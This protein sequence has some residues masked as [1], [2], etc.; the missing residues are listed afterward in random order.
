[1]FGTE[2]QKPRPPASLDAEQQLGFAYAES[3]LAQA[4]FAFQRLV[5]QDIQVCLVGL[6]DFLMIELCPLFAFLIK[7]VSLV[8]YHTLS[9]TIEWQSL[10]VYGNDRDG[11][12]GTWTKTEK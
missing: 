1:M 3:T 2:S 4:V 8:L 7:I 6:V 9:C 11:D 12:V 5:Y 10:L